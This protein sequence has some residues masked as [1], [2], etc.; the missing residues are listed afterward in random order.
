MAQNKY[1]LARYALI[2][3]LL[4]R[5]RYVKT[6]LIVDLCRKNLGCCISQ[7]MIQ[8]DIEAMKSDTFLGYYAP[9]EYSK[10]QKAYYY[11]DPEYKLHPLQ[12]SNEEKLFLL[13]TLIYVRDELSE[14][15]YEILKNILEKIR[16]LD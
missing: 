16:F 10:S 12:F 9:I 13:Q 4:R 11:A 2:D 5:N 8:K 14:K 6:L 15:E 7:R 1:A 3:S